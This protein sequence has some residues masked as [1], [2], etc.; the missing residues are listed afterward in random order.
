M[1]TSLTGTRSVPHERVRGARVD[2]GLAVY[3]KNPICATNNIGVGEHEGFQGLAIATAYWSTIIEF[4]ART[5]HRQ[6]WWLA[7]V[8]WTFLR[9]TPV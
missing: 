1:R 3:G 4:R 5:W 8:S 6:A 9:S 2:L 7:Q